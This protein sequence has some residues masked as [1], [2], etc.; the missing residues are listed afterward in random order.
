MKYGIT[1]LAFISLLSGC[2]SSTLDPLNTPAHAPVEV[3]KSP[4]DS[5]DYRYVLLDNKLRVL[6]VSDLA[7]DKSAAALAVY[8]GS[9]HEPKDRAGLAH[10]LEHMLFI[11][12]QTYPEIDGFQA[13]ISANG[14]SSNAYTALDHTNYFF[15]TKPEAFD[16]ALDR[17]AHF[18]IDPV[19][20][21]EYALREK[22]AVHSE[23]QLQMKDD[24]WRGYMVSK[25]ALNPTHPGSRFTIGSL[26]T[27]D[28]DI[29]ADLMNF[30][31]AQYSADQMGLVVLSNKSLDD[32]EAQIR[33]LFGQIPN[34]ELGADYPNVPMYADDQLPAL[35]QSESIKDGSR[36]IYNFPLPNTRQH[37]KKK[38]EQYFTNLL[39]HEGKGS[40]Y[41]AL[42]A[43]G[44][45]LSLSSTVGEFDRYHSIL[46][47]EIELTPQGDKERAAVTDLFFQY[48]DLIKTTPP[49]QWL[50]DEQ[51]QVAKIAF[52]FQEKSQ[53]MGFVYR[54]APSINEYPAED[55]LASRF[56]MEEFDGALIQQ[57]L[58]YIREDNLLV[59][60]S[61]PSIQATS[62]EPWF[63][64]PYALALGPIER[65]R[66]P[67]AEFA[68]PTANPYLPDDLNL[69]PTD[70]KSITAI[71]NKPGL[72]L[73]LD[74]DTSFG[75]P[76]A[77]LKLRL[78]IPGGLETPRDRAVAQL[79]RSM[80]EDNLS[81]ITYPAYLAGLGYGLAVP[82]AG[83]SIS[84]GGY[85]DNQLELLQTVLD[86]LTHGSLNQERFDTLKASLILDW[87]NT[88]KER[89]YAQAFAA[90]SDTLRSGRWP[91]ETLVESLQPLTL[92]ELETWRENKLK[93][94]SVT[95]LFHGNVQ[96]TDVVALEK[97]LSESLDLKL[98][99]VHRPQVRS[100]EDTLL[101]PLDID[102]D[103][104]AMVLHVQ[105]PD[106]SF[107]SRA[108]SS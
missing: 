56:L 53:P 103:D 64:V 14:G 107:A 37:Y 2:T 41:Q 25:Q 97:L 98:T 29:H 85:Q 105:D 67:Q 68:L 13:Y 100:V 90:L 46:T 69:K 17:F 50:Y 48:I 8:R 65:D 87:R 101:L 76:R 47:V 89:P 35:L 55:L 61:A 5:R 32:L 77:N 80:V 42:S 49:Q 91:R 51:A 24:G 19:L 38:P 16:G 30:F 31:D 22:N 27:L 15:D 26:D 4:N 39:G 11:Q 1:L 43:K 104:A 81:E 54:L 63:Q 60:Y 21:E 9:F 6:L 40:L 20:S 84:I 57:Y 79:Y 74:T 62:T 75:S 66:Q 45:I 59:E 102:H 72:S 96:H 7:T 12:T 73:W 34:K 92:E 18:F 36:I 3:R 93:S 52:R 78:A 94:F 58:S 88:Q 83:F 99:S 23:Y 95:G 106:D 28:G 70:E 10:F 82:D 44:W 71:L 108:K 86:A 33:P